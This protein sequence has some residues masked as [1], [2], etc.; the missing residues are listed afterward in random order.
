MFALLLNVWIMFNMVCFSDLHKAY[1]ARQLLMRKI[2]STQDKAHHKLFLIAQFIDPRSSLTVSK[3][4][5]SV[6]RFN[7]TTM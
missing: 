5:I 3:A 1:P 4:K 2:I 7:M 6:K